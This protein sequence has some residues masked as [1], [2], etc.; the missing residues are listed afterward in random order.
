MVL[1]GAHNSN[2]DKAT[3]HRRYLGS[4]VMTYGAN[5]GCPT[6]NGQMLS[7]TI[8]LRCMGIITQHISNGQTLHAVA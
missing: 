5:F 4:A 3:P 6:S 1:V 7:R 8:W 2:N